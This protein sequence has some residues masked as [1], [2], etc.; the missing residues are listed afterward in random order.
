[1]VIAASLLCGGLG[2][3][4]YADGSSGVN[5]E[6][7]YSSVRKIYAQL[8]QIEQAITIY[9]IKHGNRLPESLDELFQFASN[10]YSY[11]KKPLLGKEDLIDPWGEP[12]GYERDGRKY[13][14]WS[15][16]PDKKLGTK[17][18][19]VEGGP[20]SYVKDWIARHAQDVDG[21]ETD[22]VQ[23]ATPEPAPPPPSVAAEPQPAATVKSP[24][25]PVETETPARVAPPPKQEQ[26]EPAEPEGT[27]WKLPLLIGAIIIGTAAAWRYF[28]K[29]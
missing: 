9:M 23:M 26:N 6:I 4:G 20:P 11:F 28:R 19:F 1:M 8:T 5:A 12:F 18:D 16:G 13:V 17:D 29:K 7:R 14:L 2:V 3:S 10:N 25:A 15:S 27:P 21:Q 24:P 22:V